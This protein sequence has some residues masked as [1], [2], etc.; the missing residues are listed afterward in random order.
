MPYVDSIVQN[1]LNTTGIGFNNIVSM[2]TGEY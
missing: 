2:K 1:Y